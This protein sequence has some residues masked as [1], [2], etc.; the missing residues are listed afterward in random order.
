MLSNYKF[1]LTIALLS[2]MLY[3]L[4]LVI[5]KILKKLADT[6]ETILSITYHSIRVTSI[7]LVVYKTKKKKS[8]F[9]SHNI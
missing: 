6:R 3:L 2:L 1:I 5:L 7:K 8:L 9:F 4:R